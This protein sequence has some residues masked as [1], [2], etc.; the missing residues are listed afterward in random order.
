MNNFNT[1]RFARYAKFDLAVNKNFYRNMALVVLATIVGMVIVSFFI[2]WLTF[3]VGADSH[4]YNNLTLTSFV[5]MS[6]IGYAFYISAGCTLHPL[7]NKQGRITHLTLPATNLE[8]YLWHLLICLGG[9]FAVILVSV[10]LADLIN[11]LMSILVFES[12]E[13]IES[14]FSHIFSNK[15][16]K[17]STFFAQFHANM[18]GVSTDQVYIDEEDQLFD[19]LII[20]FWC[21]GMST[22]FLKV[23]FYGFGNT[24]KYKFNILITYIVLKIGEFIIATLVF[25]FSLVFTSHLEDISHEQVL[26]FWENMETIVYVLAAICFI[27]AI[28]MWFWSY[29]RYTKAQL[30]NTLNR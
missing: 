25:I 24:L 29:K 23:S 27:G 9:C 12:S 28:G 18:N 16:F 17:I 26:F 1:Q 3:S 30:C 7:R 8:K 14:L 22:S 13:G 5:I 6:L 10:G 20:A 21:F 4:T 2:R 15:D 11:Y 19:N